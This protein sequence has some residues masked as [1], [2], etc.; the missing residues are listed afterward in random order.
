MSI[1][2]DEITTFGTGLNRPECVLAHKSGLVF[3]SD[4]TDSGGVTII[5][6]D[7]QIRRILCDYQ[8]PLRPNGISLESGGTFLLAHWDVEIN[9]IVELLSDS[10]SKK[11]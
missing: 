1:N 6:P 3:V 10:G 8:F 11:Y 5:K 2:L 4:W 7:G 9:S